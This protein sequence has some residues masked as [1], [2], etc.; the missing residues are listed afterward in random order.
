MSPWILCR[1][2]KTWNIEYPFPNIFVE[3][4]HH[5]EDQA[6]NLANQNLRAWHKWHYVLPD[7]L[8]RKITLTFITITGMAADGPNQFFQPSCKSFA[9][10]CWRQRPSEPWR[11][12]RPI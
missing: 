1:L 12:Y 8:T 6:P 5:Q 4:H 9:R 7:G 3:I 10:H 11:A 2:E